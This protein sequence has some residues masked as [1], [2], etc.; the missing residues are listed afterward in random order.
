MSPFPPRAS[1]HHAAIVELVLFFG[2]VVTMSVFVTEE[3]AAAWRSG[4]SRGFVP[5]SATPGG[6]ANHPE[7]G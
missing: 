4:G 5:R 7:H 2:D 3:P 1:T 6:R